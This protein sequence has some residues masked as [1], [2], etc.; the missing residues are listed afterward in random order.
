MKLS[1]VLAVYN[2]EDTLGEQLA[3]L[4]RQNWDEPWEL[5]VVNNASK[6]QSKTIAESFY[7]KIP[8][9]KI[10]DA[11]QRKGAAYARNQGVKVA[12][13]KMIAFCDADDIVRDNWVAEIAAAIEQNGFVCGPMS[14]SALN[15]AWRIQD[16]VSVRVGDELFHASDLF[17]HQ[18]PPFPEDGFF[19][20]GASCNM[21]V[22]KSIHQDIGGFDEDFLRD[23]DRDYCIRAQLKGYKLYFAPRAIVE[24]RYKLSLRD[25]FSQFRGWGKWLMLI[26]KKYGP[27][28]TFRKKISYVFGG[29]WPV[30]LELMKIRSIAGLFAFTAGFAHRL[31]QSQ[32]CIEFMVLP[33]IKSWFATRFGKSKQVEGVAKQDP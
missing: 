26:P 4:A 5:I 28:T 12:Q 19:K 18:F 29:W 7:S 23:Q 20:T 31:G 27:P 21:G 16:P 8:N 14:V 6:D 33:D 15:P 22:L 24:Y 1:V 2:A 9:L 17:E 25:T 11:S 10:I 30:P 32:G 3:A 13:A